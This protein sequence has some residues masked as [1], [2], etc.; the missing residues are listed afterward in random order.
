M[1]PNKIF[2]KLFSNHT[3]YIVLIFILLAII[4]YLHKELFYICLIVGLFVSCYAVLVRAI[5][6]NE[7]N[8][9]IEQLAFNVDS[10]TKD[11]LLNFK[12]PLVILE[13]DGNIIWKN[14]N[15]VPLFENE[16]LEEKLA[17]ILK[18]FI[19]KQQENKDNVLHIETQIAD[20]VYD[21]YANIVKTDKRKMNNHILLM[22]FVDK[23][24]YVH[25]MDIY[26]KSSL[27]VGVI[28]IDNY[29]EVFP[30]IPEDKRAQLM[31]IIGKMIRN[32]LEKANGI[33]ID[34]ERSRFI[35][36][37]Q[38]GYI[39]ELKK[40]RFSIL[41]DVKKIDF[42]ST[43]PV[44]ISGGIVTGNDSYI[45]K[46]L[47]ALSTLNVALGRGG[48]QIVLN[49]DGK[50][51]FFGEQTTEIEKRTKVK[52]RVMSQALIKLI[53]NSKN[54][55]IM[56]HKD[57]DVDCLGAGLGIYRLANTLG[58]EAY[59]VLD[60]G[61]KPIKNILEKIQSNEVYSSVVIN[62]NEA[63]SK[64]TPDTLLIVVD[65]HITNM[66]EVPELLKETEQIVVIDHHRRSI[67]SIENTLLTFHEVYASSAA[68]LVTE[69]I[70]YAETDIELEQLEA[71]S[72][73]AGI[74]VDTKNF[75]FKTGVRT[76]EAAAY[77]RKYGI[78]IIKVKKWFQ[79]DLDSYNVIADIV[80][81][82]QIVNETVGIS[83]YE[84]KDKSANLICAKAADELLTI[85]NIT[86]SFVIGNLGDKICISGRS[87]GDINVQVIL[88][89]LR[90]RRTY[91]F[92]R[93]SS[94]RNDYG[95]SKRR[96]NSKNNRIFC[97]KFLKNTKDNK[98][99]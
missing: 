98:N 64:I 91:Y 3:I 88:E 17:G 73:Y 57:P 77:L 48:D 67:D 68:E 10:V 1:N 31:P 59:I 20:R 38:K 54:I 33:V 36:L 80:K 14:D 23:T 15:F 84:E 53:Q 96:T 49:I 79:S 58:K 6:K 70:E 7:I 44:T 63:L 52:S 82:V 56:G 22:Y 35:I 43:M 41:E 2:N 65:T 18:S 4:L 46:Y 8:K 21:I 11:A 34:K 93:S 50:Y 94:G 75:T 78:D 83:Q 45:K 47:E 92:S 74:M 39:E 95:G 51:E 13:S 60:N 62:K 12:M 86:A 30:T 90:R 42:G 27:C 66:V 85:N 28:S 37:F 81:N 71:E 16:N 40:Q 69:I 97:R 19:N 32:W 25:L 99:K 72:L 55:I 26:D 76:F 24:D 89:K 61:G 29:E 9:Y 87:I 5:R